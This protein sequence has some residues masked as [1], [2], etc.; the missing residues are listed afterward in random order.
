MLQAMIGLVIISL[1]IATVLI[2]K[3]FIDIEEI[4]KR[5]KK[6]EEE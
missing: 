1:F 5:I 6:L 3:L 2:A 4:R